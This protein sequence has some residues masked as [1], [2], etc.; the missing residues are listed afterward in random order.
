MSRVLRIM[1]SGEPSLLAQKSYQKAIASYQRAAR[2]GVVQAP[3]KGRAAAREFDHGELRERIGHARRR[4]LPQ[5]PDE[6]KQAQR[7]KTE[8]QDQALD[9]GLPVGEEESEHGL[10]D[11]VAGRC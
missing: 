4:R 2:R 6:R 9:P 7:A 8:Q 1:A 5:A 11:I 3:G 10:G